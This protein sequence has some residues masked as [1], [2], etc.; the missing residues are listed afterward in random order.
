[1]RRT[2]SNGTRS[3]TAHTTKAFCG[4]KVHFSDTR[5][6]DEQE[7]L[8]TCMFPRSMRSRC[9]PRKDS[10]CDASGGVPRAPRVSLDGF[11][12]SSVTLRTVRLVGEGASTVFTLSSSIR[13]SLI[14]HSS[15]IKNARVE[16]GAAGGGGHVCASQRFTLL[17]RIHGKHF[18]HGRCRHHLQ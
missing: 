16:A 15:R 12:D 1:M 11:G 18:F 8:S 9:R 5:I 14:T 10:R 6:Y 3:S 2:A 17:L 13:K 4:R 7:I